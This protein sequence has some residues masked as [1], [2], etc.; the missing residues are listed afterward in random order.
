M[1]GER[2]GELEELTLLAVC[3]VK[4]ETY[5]VPVQQFVEK[6]SGRR[7]T[8]GAVYAALERLEE[9]GFVRSVMGTAR[10]MRGGRRKRLFQATPDGI[11]ALKEIRRVREHIW[12]VI[13]AKGRV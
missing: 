3:A 1:K 10:Q 8:I 12:D 5:G 4:G 13:E 11:E 7:V 6:T 2:L 9:K